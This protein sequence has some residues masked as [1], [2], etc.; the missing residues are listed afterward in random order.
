MK[1]IFAGIAALGLALSLGV[2]TASA[3]DH[4]PEHKVAICHAT[5]STTNPYNYI[6]VAKQSIIKGHA[7]DAHQD[8]EDII[9]P[10]DGYE[11]RNW[12]TEGQ[13]IYANGCEVPAEPPVEEPPII[14]PPHGE[15]NPL[16][17]PNEET[18]VVP[19]PATYI[20]GT[21][22]DPHGTVVIP[23]Q[24]EGVIV[25]EGLP[26]L[27]E[28]GEWYGYLFADTANGYIF[29]DGTSELYYSFTVQGP[30]EDCSIPETV[31]DEEPVTETPVVDTPQ[32]VVVEVPTPVVTAESHVAPEV[33]ETQPETRDG[34]NV[35]TAA[36]LA[37]TGSDNTGLLI[38]GGL[39]LF[40]LGGAAI[41]FSRRQNA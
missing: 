31:P 11:G 32:A 3:D 14:P 39:L 20:P 23:A 38:S 15:P 40:A 41:Y 18:P 17:E 5:H 1:K 4:K 34:L 28:N 8:A 37:D 29:T 27:N 9:P 26:K 19:N 2:G 7:H 24:P 22:L 35:Q 10:F 30:V 36:S 33:I 25:P 12:T 21:C 6:E 16:P 13:T